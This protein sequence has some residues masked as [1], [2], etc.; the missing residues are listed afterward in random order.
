[1][2]TCKVWIFFFLGW[3]GVFKI[4]KVCCK[5]V[6]QET[7]SVLG[8]QSWLWGMRGHKQMILGLCSWELDGFC[9]LPWRNGCFPSTSAGPTTA[10]APGVVLMFSWRGWL[11]S[12]IVT[13]GEW[14]SPWLLTEKV[15][16][17]AV[18]LGNGALQLCPCQLASFPLLLFSSV[19]QIHKAHQPAH[20]PLTSSAWHEPSSCNHGLVWLEGVKPIGHWALMEL[21]VPV[22]NSCPLLGGP[23]DWLEHSSRGWWEDKQAQCLFQNCME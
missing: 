5:G 11:V 18:E 19:P 7:G 4:P 23:L 22:P 2:L 16:A 10:T 3:G 20:C 17:W 12:L 8:K 14:H 13:E 15:S 1:M 9:S 6:W 21:W